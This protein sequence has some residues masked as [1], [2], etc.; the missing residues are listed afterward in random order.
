VFDVITARK[1]AEQA[2]AAERQFL[3]TLIDTMPDMIFV[4]DPDGRFTLANAAFAAKVGA[5]SSQSLL[6][7][8]DY[9]ISPRDVADAYRRDDRQVM[10]TGATL[11]NREET[12]TNAAG[13]T[14]HLLT[15]KV[16][17]LKPDDTLEGLLG[18]CRD[19][20][21]RANLQHEKARMEEQ[22]RQAQKMESVGRLAGGVAHDFNNMLQAIL[23][24]TELALLETPV[25]TPLHETLRQIE[26]AAL[27]S[28]E[29]TR[30]LLAFARKQTIQPRV[31]NLNDIV[32]HLH[33]ILR[34]LI[35]ENIELRWQPGDALWPV[36]I[37]PSQVEQILTNLTVN[38]RDA[39][40]GV[41]RV[42]IETANTTLD[43]SYCD[44]HPEVAP[45]DYVVLTV[46]DNG[47]G[48]D[49]DVL[50]HAFEPFF[51]TKQLG[52]GLGLATVYGIVRQNGGSIH[53]YSEPGRGA[54]FR[55]YLPRHADAAAAVAPAAPAA[56]VQTGTETVLLVEDEAI[57]RQQVAQTLVRLGYTVLVADK[58]AEAIR[59]VQEHAGAIHLLITDVIM[60][61]MNGRALAERLMALRPGLKCLF[62]SG[63]TADV[64][65]RGGVL[66]DGLHFIQKPFA[67][68]EIAGKIRQTLES[69]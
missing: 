13:Q 4:K 36:R 14:C 60:P 2:L 49:K 10:K 21:D 25:Q 17:L 69:A 58:P 26:I 29:L 42:N 39:I 19:V 51:T 52:T 38:A 12:M 34:R 30:K 50:A 15:T 6:G 53:A 55:I 63:Y 61:E 46:S 54:T 44:L 32:T 41:G 35:G 31:L 1:Q 56:A 68:V 62:I 57:I 64:I 8:T 28:A 24:H 3:S 11:L 9:D 16:A 7:K 33:G 43:A 66:E 59:L 23:G 65:A 47:R 67:T 22:L 40:D 45:G 5:P 27:H 37:D 48:I 18:I 20:T